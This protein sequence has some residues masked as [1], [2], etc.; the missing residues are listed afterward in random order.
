MGGELP[1][2]HGEFPVVTRG[3]SDWSTDPMILISHT[4]WRFIDDRGQDFRERGP[5]MG[6]WVVPV[7]V[8]LAIVL[9]SPE[10]CGLWKLSQ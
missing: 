7:T 8:K 4:G 10:S 9:H 5:E 2:L 3:S 1:A 6:R